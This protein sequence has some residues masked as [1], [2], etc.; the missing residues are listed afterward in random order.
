MGGSEAWIGAAVLAAVSG[1]LG[2][3]RLWLR[4]RRQASRERTVVDLVRAGVP[5][6]QVGEVLRA[7][8]APPRS[9][10]TSD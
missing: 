8:E 3:G 2:I 4:A 6:S 5:P 9:D 10:S 1:L 7:T